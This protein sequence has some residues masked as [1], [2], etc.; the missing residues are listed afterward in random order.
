MTAAAPSAESPTLHIPR[1]SQ[2][3]P[4]ESFLDRAPEIEGLVSDFRQRDPGDGVPASR[5]TSALLSYDD[6]HLYVV[7][8]CEEE[9]NKVRARLAKREAIDGDDQVAIYLDTFHDRQR[10]Y[11]FASNPLGIQLDG[12]VTE[13]QEVDYSYDTLWHTEGRLTSFGYVV[14]MAIPFRSLRFSSRSTQ[15]WGIALSRI[16][17]RLNEESYWPYITKRIQGFV[18]QFARSDGLERISPGRNLQFIPYSLFARARFLDSESSLQ[19]GFQSDN[20]LRSGLD[21]KAVLRDALTLDI[22]VNPDFSQVET[23]DPQV[24]INQRFEVFFPERRPFFIENAGFFGTPTNLFFSRRVADPQFGVRLTG[25]VGRWALG[26]LAIDDRAPGKRVAETSPLRR[27]R[28]GIG[29]VA[30]RREFAQ[31]SSIGLLATSRD[32]GSSSNRVFSLDTRLQLNPN[33]TLVGQLMRS[34]TRE[35]GSGRRAGDGYLAELEHDGR[36]FDYLARY[37]DLSPDFRSQLGF[38]KR[39]DLRQ[40]DQNIEYRWRPEQSRIVKFGPSF[41]TLVNWDHQGRLQDWRFAPQFKIEFT[42]Q[43]KLKVEHAQAFELFENFK[44]HKR[45]TTLEFSTE[46]LK[47]LAAS[48]THSWGTEVNFSPAQGL[49]PFR[50]RMAESELALTLRPAPRLRVDNTYIYSRL[51]TE[52]D[53]RLLPASVSSNI[54]TNHIVRWKLNYQFTRA[55]SARAILDYEA[56]LPNRFLV[57]LEREKRFGADLLLTYLVN[58][59]TA[60]HIGYTDLY[61]NLALDSTAGASLRRTAAPTLSTGRQ[62]FIKL[63]YLFRY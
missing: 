59:G 31:Q 3:P 53:F 49:D 22:T 55:L 29:V 56:V 38:V 1:V 37:T 27:R 26:A 45:A 5:R 25:K 60:L 33:W 18:P 44:F 46:W 39:V 6:K 32:F 47:W 4:L 9:P 43:T 35:V 34:S 13:G 19:P 42:G 17:P 62:F 40:A 51:R 61:E 50:A 24:T 54:F 21:F 36:H 2:P 23:D 57:D 28:A 41:E 16:I 10:A 30:V 58:P 14:W 12:I 20:E 8:V 48:V 15:R 63:S 52:P 7:F 11:L